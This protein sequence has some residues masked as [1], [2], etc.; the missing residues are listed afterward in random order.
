MSVRLKLAVSYVGF[1]MVAWAAFLLV[2]AYVLRFVP[3]A[4]LTV[5]GDDSFAPGRSDLVEVALP[6]ALWGTAALALVGLAGG[7][8]LAGRMLRPLAAIGA[9][10]DRVAR[11][12]LSDRVDLPGPAD[13]LRRLADDFDHM[14]DRLESAFAEQ[15]RFTGNASHELQT[16][17]AV[18]RTMLEVARVDPGRDV[19]LLID[20]LSE[21]NDRS[22]HSLEALLRL[23]QADQIAPRL[24][25]C[26]LAVVL[27]DG[28]ETI[29]SPARARGTEIHCLLGAAPVTAD[30]LLLC[31]LA[32]NL[33]ANA[34]SHNVASGGRIDVS[35]GTDGR[36]RRAGPSRPWW[37]SL[38][39]RRSTAGRWGRATPT[40]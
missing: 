29:T 4:N 27:G 21:L 40:R 2:M 19:D 3:E 39:G 5:V 22:I 28:I 6:V 26:D 25:P 33:L 14:M 23:A 9:V 18:V 38:S 7:W 17:H 20:R 37:S 35:S 10:T 34:V 32:D 8:L 24:E 11:G 12:S 1:L 30:P 36:G 16:P 31:H 15:Q 13:E